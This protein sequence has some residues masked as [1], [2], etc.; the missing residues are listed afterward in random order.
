[1]PKHVGGL[2]RRA[3]RIDRRGD[4]AHEGKRKVEKRPL[5][6]SLADDSEGIALAHSAREQPIGE[7][8]DRSGCLVP[9]DL[10]PATRLGLYEVGGPRTSSRNSVAPEAHDRLLTTCAHI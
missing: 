3:V 8:V 2:L 4:R 9:R 5:E 7:L 1:M 10:P 6:P